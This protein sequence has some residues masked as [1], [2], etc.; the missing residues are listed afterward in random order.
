MVINIGAVKGKNYDLVEKDIKAVVD[1]AGKELT[2]VIIETCY[3]TNE[4]K[5]ECCKRAVAAGA[6]YVKTS[7]GFGTNGATPED[8]KLMK[9]TVGDKA[10]V[11]AAGGVRTYEDAMKMIENGASRIGA[12]AGIK[13]LAGLEK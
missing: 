7:A 12:S 10:L 2:K 5:V 11:K 6:E 13:I 3:L 8:V 9:E 4:E 1:A